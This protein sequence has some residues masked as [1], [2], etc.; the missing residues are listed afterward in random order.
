MVAGWGAKGV[1]MLV[2]RFFGI[3]WVVFVVG[4]VERHGLVLLFENGGL[5]GGGFGVLCGEKG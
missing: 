2:G 5:R 1:V 3:C 4:G